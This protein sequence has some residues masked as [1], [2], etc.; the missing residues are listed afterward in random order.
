MHTTN[1]M[2]LKLKARFFYILVLVILTGT[3]VAALY[4][5]GYHIEGGA[6]AGIAF[7]SVITSLLPY[8][9]SMRLF[10]KYELGSNEKTNLKVRGWTIYAL[11][12]PVKIW[13]IILNLDLLIN[14]GTGWSFG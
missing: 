8:F 6:I 10:T 14:G 11:C 5:G 9:I 2:S 13:I 7:A 1:T 4:D 12:F 3:T